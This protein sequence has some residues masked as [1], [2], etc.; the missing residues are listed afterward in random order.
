MNVI[1]FPKKFKKS[2]LQEELDDVIP[3]TEKEITKFTKQNIKRN[4][5]LL[6]FEK[7][8][9]GL[10]LNL[11]SLRT[12][13]IINLEVKFCV[14]AE[15]RLAKVKIQNLQQEISEIDCKITYL[16]NNLSN[17][18]QL[19]SNNCKIYDFNSRY[20]AKTA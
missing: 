17:F 11:S 8:L 5:E 19:D 10:T 2:D 20:N 7:Q 18:K 3:H 9:C 13:P 1:K 4:K 6:K 12:A 16:K 14:E 15:I